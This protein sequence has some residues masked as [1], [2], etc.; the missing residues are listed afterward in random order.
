MTADIGGEIKKG[1]VIY[2]MFWARI[3]PD[4]M[5]NS[6]VLIPN[7]GI[8]KASAPYNKIVYSDIRLTKNWQT[9]AMTGTAD[10]DYPSLGTQLNFPLSSRSQI[11]DFG[12]VFVFN[13]GQDVDMTSLPFVN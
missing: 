13:L 11:V 7:A 10:K 3:A 12:P 1:D 6:D 5:E 9:I 4:D 8:Q 2:M